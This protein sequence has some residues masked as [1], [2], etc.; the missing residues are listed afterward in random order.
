MALLLAGIDEAGYGPRLGP[1][2]V[3]LSMVRIDGWR[4]GEP[5][6]DLWSM[7][8]GAVSREPRDHHGRIAIADSKRLKLSNVAPNPL[9][10]LERGVL[11]VLHTLEARPECDSGLVAALASA[12]PPEPWYEGPPIALPCAGDIASIRIAGNQLASAMERAGVAAVALRVLA[13]GETRFNQLVRDE[14]TK[15]IATAE[16]VGSHLRAILELGGRE[17]GC[18][19]RIVCDRLGGRTRY[20]DLLASMVPDSRVKILEESEARSRYAVEAPGFAKPAIVQFQVEAESSHLPVALASM[21]AKLTR[22]LAMRRFNAYWTA[23]MPELKPTAG[24]ALDAG[25]WLNDTRAM[26]NPELRGRL[27][28]RA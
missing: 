17:P 7:L 18:N 6:P 14:G 3:G 13:M 11:A 12:W 1:L 8:D 16:C 15:A 26:L 21:I 4:E 27:V 19:L 25:R 5:A 28:R 9:K 10:H 2:C 24:Y 20:H 23:R 22:E